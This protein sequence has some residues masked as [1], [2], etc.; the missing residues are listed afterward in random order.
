M[1]RAR[2]ISDEKVSFFSGAEAFQQET[3]WMVTGRIG[4]QHVSWTDNPREPGA[5]P[6]LEG[7]PDV[8]RLFRLMQAIFQSC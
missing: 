8:E 2:V 6:C 4:C 5:I 3:R 7:K 1:P